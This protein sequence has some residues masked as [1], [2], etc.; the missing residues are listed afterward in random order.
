MIKWM[1]SWKPVA[2]FLL[3]WMAAIV[4]VELPLEERPFSPVLYSDEGDLIAATVA[5]DEQWRF[6]RSQELPEFLKDA[7]I[8]YEDE[9]FLWHPGVNPVSLWKAW[10]KNRE[11]G[12]IVRGGSTLTMQV[13]R[14]ARNR[15]NRSYGQKML[16]IL[17]AFKLELLY[18]KEE[19]LGQWC[20]LAPFGGNVQGIETAAWRF[21]G[22]PL[23]QLSRAEMATLA[24]LPNAPALIHPGKNRAALR[25]KRNA[26][27]SKLCENGIVP[28]EELPLLKAEILPQKPFDLPQKALHLLIHLKKKYPD[29]YLFESHVSRSM[30]SKANA[31]IEKALERLE[32]RGIRS[33]AALVIDLERNELKAYCGNTPDSDGDMR[34]VDLVH[35]PRSYGSLLKPMLYAYAIDRGAL[36]PKELISDVP[37]HIQGFEPDNF[38]E[39]F[40]GVV[41]F[42]EMLIQSL[43]VPAVRAL[44][45]LGY[46][47]F[48]DF[49]QA[50]QPAHLDRGAD[51]YGLSIILGGAES[52]LWSMGRMYKG[53]ARSYLGYPRPF[54]HPLILQNEKA[55]KTKLRLG[56]FAV[57][58]TVKAMCNLE[59]PREEQGWRLLR[60][61]EEVAWKTGTS[62]GHR[63]AWAV[64]FNKKFLIAVWVGNENG[65]GREGLTGINVAAPIFFDLMEQMSEKGYGLI[66]NKLYPQQVKT[67]AYTG[68]RAGPHCDS[69]EWLS[70]DKIS[71]QWRSCDAHR[72]GAIKDNYF[73]PLSCLDS[74]LNADTFFVLPATEESFYRRSNNNYFSLPPL[75]EN[76]RQEHQSEGLH[77]V[78][79]YR[80]ARIFLPVESNGERRALLARAATQGEREQLF[81]YLD[82]QFLGV[83]SEA[84]EVA[85]LPPPGQHKLTVVHE[86]GY[87]ISTDFQVSWE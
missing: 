80:E 72:V 6:P 12:K 45:Y 75:A 24:V 76:C 87:R 62:Y 52:D 13:A 78:Y 33:A 49:L 28:K 68:R 39:K 74:E 66:R 53:L 4:A 27:L 15:R 56:T 30:Q 22:R 70:V 46:R 51:H 26:L 25:D 50:M 86:D 84:H 31:A 60:P 81:W 23:H 58:H 85:C 11:A 9:Y 79:P 64:G 77:F 57:D 21:F 83:T 16:E 67:C 38:D 65:E 2:F 18:S 14:M 54:S 41:P 59:K 8:Q 32:P 7:I 1:T 43:N 36:L 71:H 3:V 42:D 40:R 29:Q 20:R 63:D 55:Q 19:I 47:T 69:I 5:R 73:H 34:Y 82:D 48:Y 17:A 37:T 35:A 61:V 44:H 10:R